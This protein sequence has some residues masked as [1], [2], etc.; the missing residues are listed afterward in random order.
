[1][2]LLLGARE[3]G[4][5]GSAESSQLLVELMTLVEAARSS[6]AADRGALGGIMSPMILR[7][8]LAALHFRDL[9]TV[10]HSRRVSQLAVGIARHLRWE[11]AN[12]KQLEIAGLLHDIGKIG[13]PDNVLFKPAK[14]NADEADLMA[15][16]H[17]IS[18]DVLQA[19]R[20]DPRVIE[21]VSQARDFACAAA[22]HPVGTPGTAS[23]GARILSV[24]DAYDALRSDQVFRKAKPHDEAMKILVE[25]TGTQFDGNVINALTRCA[26][27]SGLAVSPDYVP[28]NRPVD[29][30]GIFGDAQE[31]HDAAVLSQIFSHLYLLENLYDGFYIVDADL[32]FVLWSS[33]MHRLVGVTAENLLDHTWSTRTICYADAEGHEL[34]DADLPLRQ[35]LDAHHADSRNVRILDAAGKWTDVELQA[36]PLLDDSGRLRGVAEIFRD[37][38]RAEGAPRAARDAQ[39]SAG[40]DALT[41]VATDVELRSQLG[42]LVVAAG[43]DDWKVPFSVI[44]VEVD[45]FKQIRERFG[46]AAGD[47]A[48]IEVARLLQQETYAGEIV[49]RHGSG[50]QFMVLCPATTGEQASRRAERIRAGF[51]R[52][53]LPELKDWNLTGSF[54]II[55]AVPGD[56]VDS[57]PNRVDKALYSATH[58]GRDQTF[59]LAPNDHAEPLLRE[60][61]GAGKSGAFEYE[62]QFLAC[63]ASEM[64]VYKLG[65][66]VTEEDATLLEVTS[67]RVRMRL[68]K[69]SF[70]SRWGKTADTQPVDVDLR[71]GSEVPLR[72]VNGRK[73]KSNQVQVAVKITAV[74]RVK[75]RDMFLARARQV[76][77]GLSTYFLAE[78]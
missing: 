25:N 55:Q 35:A 9:A 56:T 26:A 67:E 2:N 42:Q 51:S 23:Q 1:M 20:V 10:H 30:S 58:G 72:D 77:K 40:R 50:G 27:E 34:L 14:L 19:A 45:H 16:H 12:L 44:M 7:K 66:F 24:A 8:L 70:F 37:R 54:G 28:Q 49:G 65:G 33:G 60:I 36:V 63:T 3:N 31:A 74:G 43:R 48:L 73:V 38:S 62:A 21:M 64:I 75:N 47:L 11:E 4:A 18:F 41:G 32:R 78:V 13:V 59:Y 69:R 57:V 53:R 76:L 52:A 15:L 68:G 6:S 39:P 71:F 5:A 61:E 29:T 22:R 46:R 17:R